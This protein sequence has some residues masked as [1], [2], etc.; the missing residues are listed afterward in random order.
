[1]L[2]RLTAADEPSAVQL[3]LHLPA[4]GHA[5]RPGGFHQL[6]A[7]L[8][9]DLLT[10]REGPRMLMKV[11]FMSSY[12]PV[13]GRGMLTSARHV[14]S[15]SLGTPSTISQVAFTGPEAGGFGARRRGL[16]PQERDRDGTLC[17]LDRGGELD[18]E[19][20]GHREAS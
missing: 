18:G 5:V 20:D 13:A 8:L 11:S 1:M 3:S 6:I 12:R 4:T 19:D 2:L 10:R 15:P 17:R 9:C 7:V 14:V 16:L